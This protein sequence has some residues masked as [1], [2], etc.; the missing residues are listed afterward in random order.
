MEI[1]ME[2]PELVEP[3]ISVINPTYTLF[4]SCV[5]VFSRVF[6]MTGIFIPTFFC[7]EQKH[8]LKFKV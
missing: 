3:K 1:T 2:I 7:M 8:T 5:D 4:F 6:R